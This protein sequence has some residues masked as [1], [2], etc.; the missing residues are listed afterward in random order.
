MVTGQQWL[1]FAAMV[2]R[3]E[4]HQ[5]AAA[6]IPDR[7]DG[8]TATGSESVL[9]RGCASA[10]SSRSSKLGQL[11]RL[12]LAALGN[13]ATVREYG[14]TCRERGRV[15]GQNPA[16]F[17]KPRPTAGDVHRGRP[18]R[19]AP[20]PAIG[21]SD[22]ESL[23]EPR[24][25]TSEAINGWAAAGW[26]AGRRLHRVLGRAVRDAWLAAIGAEVIKIESIQRPDGIRYSGGNRKDVTT[27]GSTAGS[28]SPRTSTSGRITL[29]LADHGLG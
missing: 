20:A 12:P 9:I 28:A 26:S 22:A 23:W 24:Q 13:G 10:R 1:D 4:F 11:F 8:M 3:P 21:D 2:D 19:F 18:P 17:R 29:D 27:G 7:G 14:T 5:G 16:G 6:A 15:R 25:S